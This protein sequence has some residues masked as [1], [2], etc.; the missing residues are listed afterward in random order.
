MIVLSEVFAMEKS[1]KPVIIVL[2]ALKDFTPSNS[3]L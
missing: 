3:C 1:K 2:L